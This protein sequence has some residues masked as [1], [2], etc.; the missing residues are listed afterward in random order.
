M[1]G[2]ERVKKV[3]GSLV[4]KLFQKPIAENESIGKYANVP[5]QRSGNHAPLIGT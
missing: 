1:P 4:N 5:I 3:I 2:V